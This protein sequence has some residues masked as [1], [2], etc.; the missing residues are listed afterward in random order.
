MPLNRE[1]LRAAA[2]ARAPKPATG[3]AAL[4]ARVHTGE[5]AD[6]VTIESAVLPL[7]PV[8]DGG[9]W[10][11]LGLLVV[12]RAGI[13]APPWGAVWWSWPGGAV[14]GR[15]R[16]EASGPAEPWAPDPGRLA[17]ARAELERTLAEAP[18][19]ADLAALGARYAELLPQSARAAARAI[20]GCR[21]LG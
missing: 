6:F 7:I 16:I 11:L 10:K 18:D 9:G 14:I 15:G 5:L 3:V 21:W 13:V 1:A 12:P 8:P 4:T 2:A 17:D 19:S 20:A